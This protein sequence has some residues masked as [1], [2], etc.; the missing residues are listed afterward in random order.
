MNETNA[1]CIG[2]K[3]RFPFEREICNIVHISLHSLPLAI[4]FFLCVFLF[5]LFALSLLQKITS[6]VFYFSLYCCFFLS[7]P[8]FCHC[9]AF[10]TVMFPR[11]YCRTKQPSVTALSVRTVYAV[12]RKKYIEHTHTSDWSWLC[13]LLFI[14][15]PSGSRFS[16]N[17]GTLVE[18]YLVHI[19]MPFL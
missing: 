9:K 2:H 3:Q 14:L 7:S 10:K 13:L 19:F 11:Q 6:S 15:L 16:T 17:Y 18:M 12:E 4:S 8:C 1:F 5:C